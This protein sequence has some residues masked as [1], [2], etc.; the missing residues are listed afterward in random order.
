[1]SKQKHKQLSGGGILSLV[2]LL[3]AVSFGVTTAQSGDPSVDCASAGGTWTN[4]MCQMPGQQQQP[5]TFFCN[6]VNREVSSAQECDGYD[7]Q[8][9]T[10]ES[11]G[12]TWNSSTASCTQRA[13]NTTITTTCP[14]GQMQCPAAGTSPAGCYATCPTAGTGTTNTCPAGQMQCPAA[15]TSP[16]GCYATC[17]TAGTDT[18][19]TQTQTGTMQCPNNAA[20]TCP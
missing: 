17:P 12:G 11:G 2:G 16:A 13:A 9:R 7:Q 20:P 1:M 5:T 19:N 10:C 18:T 14:A 3:V 15:G 4:N 6:A 8:K